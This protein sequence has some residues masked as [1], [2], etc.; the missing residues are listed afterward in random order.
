MPK[1]IFMGT[2]SYAERI[3]DELIACKFSIVGVFTNEDKP[4]GRKGVLKQSE[5]KHLAQSK[6]PQT[7]I[8]TPKSLKT[9]EV[10]AQIQGLKADFIVVAAYGKLLPKEIL[11]CAPCINLHASLLPK[12]RGASPIQQAILNGDET[13]GVCV[14]LM[15]ERL[16]GGAI[17]KSASLNIKNKRADEVFLKMSEL[18]ARLCVETL[19]EFKTLKALPQDESKATFCTKIKKEDGLVNLDNAKELYHKFLAFYPWPSVFLSN[20]LKFID[21]ELVDNA[22]HERDG[23]ILSVEKEGF[24]LACKTGT[25]KVKALQESGKN[26]VSA[27]D[28]INGKR[29]KSGDSLYR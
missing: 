6:I 14:M 10:L 20:G 9:S 8:F 17:L 18:A 7:P 16:D 12:Y 11:N 22:A 29:L 2:P 23:E 25:L 5:V 1:I 15:N 4:F 13:S 3:L 28:Y 24:L 27:K 26:K 21:I 19:N